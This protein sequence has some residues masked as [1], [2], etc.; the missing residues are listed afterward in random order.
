VKAHYDSPAG[1]IKTAWSVHDRSLEYR[2]EIPPNATATLY[3][4]SRPTETV[5]VDGKPLGSKDGVRFLRFEDGAA[6]FALEPGSHALV[7]QFAE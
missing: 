6:V 2:A 4:P 3:L 5:T 1:P 7:S